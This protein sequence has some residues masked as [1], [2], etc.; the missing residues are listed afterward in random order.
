MKINGALSGIRIADFSWFAVGPGIASYLAD[1]GATAIRIESH[2]RPDG[3]RS[4][5]PFKD[6]KPGINRSGVFSV[7]NSDHYGSTLN[8]KHPRAKE[9]AK[10]FVK[11][12]DVVVENFTPGTMD[13]LGLG[14]EQ[15]SKIKPD[16]I[17]LSTC[18]QGQTGPHANHPGFGSHL[19][20]LSGFVSMS[21]WPDRDPAV[22]WGPYTDFVSLGFGVVAL[23]AALDYKRR[24]G[25]GLQIDLSQYE[26]SL[27]FLSPF[28]LD[29]TVNNRV[30]ARNGNRCAY[31]S[32]HGTYPCRGEDRWVAI[33]VLTDKQWKTFCEASGYREWETDARFSSLALRKKNEEVLD[34]LVTSWT[35]QY[36]AEDVAARLQSV[37][38][39]CEVLKNSHEVCTDPQLNYL[40]KFTPLTH[41]EMGEQLYEGPG[42]ILSKT[43]ADLHMASPCL[44]QHNEMVYTQILGYSD[45]EF[46]DLLNSGALD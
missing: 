14:W 10:R 38:V 2:T 41:P 27:P 37:G 17:M 15:L 8:L 22:I 44:G 30:A 34:L 31:A 16:L 45:E 1:H 28:L 36:E 46:T 24:T 39:P 9:V 20:S 40:G 25:K 6:G 32:P 33:A 29:F 4:T 7:F 42:Y 11:W 12:A 23:I 5:P 26:S 43:P 13:R 19:T 21:G 35:A 18:N 3:F